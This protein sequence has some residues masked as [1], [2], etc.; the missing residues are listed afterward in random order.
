MALR[1]VVMISSTAKDLPE[2]REQVRLA[3]ERAGFEPRWMMEH[4]TAENRN[5]VEV[6][7]RMV[8]E[9]DVYVGVLGHR[10]GTVPPGYDLSITELEFNHA[11]ELGKPYLV[12]LIHED[13][14]VFIKDVETGTG[15]DK[16]NALKNRLRKDRVAAYFKSP[17]DLRSHAGEALRKLA[18]ELEASEAGNSVATIGSDLHRKSS[19]PELPNAY[20]A[21][22][23]TL[24]QSRELVGR[25]TELNALTDW[26]LKSDF[27]I[28]CF[29]AIGGIGKSALTWKWFNQIAPNEMKQLAGRLWWSFYESDATFESFLIRALC[30][31]GGYN[32]DAVRAMPWHE[33][34]ERLLRYLSEEPYLIG[35]RP[36]WGV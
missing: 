23:Y 3:C 31:V 28:L 12:F 29:V 36:V 15:A 24:L 33:R 7:L 17:E 13:H 2:H 32:E 26:V 22:P 30:Y 25:Q 21:H 11:V 19:I 6:S 34:E 16:L 10:Y 9:A 18:N 35:K 8:G 1:K 14:P 20:I 4:L 27:S 5:A